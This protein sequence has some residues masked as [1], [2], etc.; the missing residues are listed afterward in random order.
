[1]RYH[2]GLRCLGSSSVDFLNKRIIRHME[3][4]RDALV[5][6]LR[7]A[8]DCPAVCDHMQ[9]LILSNDWEY[10]YPPRF[11]RPFIWS[12]VPELFSDV[13]VAL[14]YLMERVTLTRL[15][16]CGFDC[17]TEMLDIVARHRSLRQLILRGCF[18]SG[19]SVT[20]AQSLVLV[21]IT[22][23]TME[24]PS[25]GPKDQAQRW[26]FLGL[27]P[28]VEEVHCYGR[29]GISSVAY[30]S[31]ELYDAVVPFANIAKLRITFSTAMIEFL[32][33]WFEYNVT[34]VPSRLT[35]LKLH[36]RRGITFWRVRLLLRS[37]G[38][39][40]GTLQALSIDGLSSTPLELFD[41]I[42][43]YIPNIRAL[44]LVRRHNASQFQ[45]K[46][47]PWDAP[48]YEYAKRLRLLPTLEHFA[49]NF[50]WSSRVYSP[51][52]L[53]DLLENEECDGLFATEYSE[54]D[55]DDLDDD[56]QTMHDRRDR[57]DSISGAVDV[58]HAFTA[59]CPSLASFAI[60]ASYVTLR[61]RIS[62]KSVK[63]DSGVVESYLVHDVYDDRIIDPFP[64][65][66]PHGDFWA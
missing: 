23:V 34:C 1:M 35:H 43:I 3:V 37:L 51:R 31:P 5:Q 45:A 48:V 2:R 11:P 62:R 59:Y 50:D 54:S 7:A 20:P 24:F 39:S 44:T 56:Y 8:G 13:C 46:L 61:C 18:L 55:T 12:G 22:M 25:P 21:N 52:L 64:E 66:D 29:D 32:P 65:W 41:D 4:S 33:P 40:Q 53:D 38:H 17:S 15:S 58:V 57:E 49:A 9:A 14:E 63:T 27:I 26:L 6:S 47:C 60:T 19:V 30:P 10:R 36:S 16:L 28:N 42:A